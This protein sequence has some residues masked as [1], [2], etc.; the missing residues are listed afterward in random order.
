MPV[1]CK[2]KSR[3]QAFASRQKDP[4]YRSWA[5]A[6]RFELSLLLRQVTHEVSQTQDNSLSI[7]IHPGASSEDDLYNAHATRSTSKTY[8]LI[9]DYEVVAQEPMMRPY[10]PLSL[11]FGCGKDAEA[12]IQK[13]ERRPT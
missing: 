3:R 6:G 1:V 4:Y 2:K 10:T 9:V 11:S 13:L 8:E 12:T 7:S 5:R